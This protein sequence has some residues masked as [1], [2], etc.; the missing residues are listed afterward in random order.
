MATCIEWLIAGV[1]SIVVNGLE[2]EMHVQHVETII[3]S[4]ISIVG[5]NHRGL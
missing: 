5:V 1:G 4:T 2:P 3:V